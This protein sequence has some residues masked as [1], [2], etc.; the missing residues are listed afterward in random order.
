[1]ENFK[2]EDV[3]RFLGMDLAELPEYTPF[4]EEHSLDEFQWELG[5]VAAA[6]KQAGCPA[7]QI[8]T[9]QARALFLMRALY[10]LGV[11]RGGEAARAAI[12]EDDD[13]E[14][15]KFSLSNIDT[16]HFAKELETASCSTLEDLC[17]IAGLGENAF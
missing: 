11:F 3:Q 6:L 16:K 2:K 14:A 5:T 15:K 1:M 13:P 17:E 8:P 4:S 10:F 12:L 9:G 7:E